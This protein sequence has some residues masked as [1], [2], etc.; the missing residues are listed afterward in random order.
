MLSLQ[1]T[2]RKF[3]QLSLNEP[4]CPVAHVTFLQSSPLSKHARVTASSPKAATNK[5]KLLMDDSVSEE[6]SSKRQR[7]IHCQATTGSTV[8]NQAN[9]FQAPSLDSF[10]GGYLLQHPQKRYTTEEVRQLL[11]ERD[12]QLRELFMKE[13]NDLLKG[14]LFFEKL[15]IAYL[16]LQM[17]SNS[18]HSSRSTATM[19]LDTCLERNV[20]T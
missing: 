19:F 16:V 14:N 4:A 18:T 8:N 7:D 6:K 1:P 13:L 5:R 2:K 20:P 17:Q 10:K 12:D 3:D 11:N 9:R 15:C